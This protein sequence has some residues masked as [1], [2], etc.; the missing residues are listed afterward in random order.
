MITSSR[1][2]SIEES[3]PPMSE[4]RT[5]GGV[6][7]FGGGF[8]SLMRLLPSSLVRVVRVFRFPVVLIGAV[9]AGAEDPSSNSGVGG[10]A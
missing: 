7:S 2:V 3:A 8:A 9:A 10:T 4:R 1:I 6:K 5:A